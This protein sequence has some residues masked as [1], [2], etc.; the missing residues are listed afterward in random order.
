MQFVEQCSRL[1]GEVEDLVVAV[2]DD[3][4]RRSVGVGFEPA[5]GAPERSGN[6]GSEPAHLVDFVAW[7]GPVVGPA[8]QG[9]DAPAARAEHERGAQLVCDAERSVEIGVDRRMGDVPVGGAN[10]GCHRVGTAGEGVEL[11]E[12]WRHELVVPEGGAGLRRK[13]L[14]KTAGRQERP[15][16]DGHHSA[17]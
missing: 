1:D 11:V 6:E 3:H 14:H 13:A 8:H 12:T 10:Q 5:G 4:G 17:P 15:R 2:Y 9:G 16:V 7:K